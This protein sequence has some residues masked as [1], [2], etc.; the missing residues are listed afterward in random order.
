MET[1]M[2]EPEDTFVEEAIEVQNSENFAMD[3]EKSETFIKTEIFDDDVVEIKPVGHPQL[4]ATSSYV[5]E[6]KTKID[7]K[8]LKNVKTRQ[9]AAVKSVVER[10]KTAREKTKINVNSTDWKPHTPGHLP[11]Y[12]RKQKENS[13]KRS[14]TFQLDM[15][16]ANNSSTNVGDSK[17]QPKAAEQG[18]MIGSSTS[19]PSIDGDQSIEIEKIKAQNS[20][21]QMSMRTEIIDLKIRN[22][23]LEKQLNEAVAARDKSINELKSSLDK[24][25]SFETKLG[26]K[27]IEIQSKNERLEKLEIEVANLIK[28][29][30]DMIVQIQSRIEENQKLEKR[31]E[32]LKNELREKSTSYETLMTEKSQL[33]V[34]LEEK[35]VGDGLEELNV[36][37]AEKIETLA[38]ENE[39]LKNELN[40]KI[41]EV[42]SLKQDKF[43]LI[44][45]INHLKIQMN[46]LPVD[47]STQALSFEIADLEEKMN[48]MSRNEKELNQKILMLN[49]KLD[50]ERNT[51]IR[52]NT[53]LEYRA[54]Y[55]KTLQAVDNVNKARL[56]LHVKE[57][58]DTREQIKGFEKFKAAHK[59]EKGNFKK[60]L[61]SLETENTK[62]KTKVEMYEKNRF[63]YK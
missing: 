26:D 8:K 10:P 38:H 24:V 2:E 25:R 45:E 61:K 23:S 7:L 19:V 12:L 1:I 31:M 52:N 14:T 35:Q 33:E 4:I 47:S 34:K 28:H 3:D 63:N 17:P 53:L 43:N 62:L 21:K 39:A 42:D 41:N 27:L 44:G 30:Q 46:K 51:N 55:I 58:E 15:P 40:G 56:I 59:E 29:K 6:T 50:D 20:A 48:V 57:L 54:E 36:Q 32:K 37:S 11:S 13:L 16:C 60:L 49:S 5:V 18:D 9:A 22:D